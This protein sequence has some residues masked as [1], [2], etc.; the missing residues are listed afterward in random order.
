MM[1][2]L[3]KP[4]RR[5]TVAPGASHNVA[6]ELV[7][8]LYPGGVLGLREP[9]RRRE[10]RVALAV[11]YERALV[12]ETLAALRARRRPKSRRVGRGLLRRGRS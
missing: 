8:T 5:R 9:R 2:R 12:E 7:A 11:I 4:V 10:V 3:S 1:T 6:S